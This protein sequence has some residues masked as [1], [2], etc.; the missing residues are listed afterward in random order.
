MEAKIK[1]VFLESQ[2][3]W[4]LAKR[5]NPSTSGVP[6]DELE[7]GILYNTNQEI[8]VFIVINWVATRISFRPIKGEG[9]FYCFLFIYSCSLWI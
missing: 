7:V 5:N 8:T 1:V 9:F 4:E 3:W 6:D 2:R